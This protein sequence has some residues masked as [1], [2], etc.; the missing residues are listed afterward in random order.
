MRLWKKSSTW[1]GTVCFAFFT[2][3]GRT[4][5]RTRYLRFHCLYHATQ[6]QEFD[7]NSRTKTIGCVTCHTIFG[8]LITVYWKMLKCNYREF[9]TKWLEPFS[10]ANILSYFDLSVDLYRAMV[11]QWNLY[12]PD[13]CRTE[14]IVHSREL[15]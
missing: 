9:N 5:V 13:T 8:Y 12:T 10:Y 2:Q 7:E 15:F 6:T 14:V 4:M 11:I 3:P 1:L